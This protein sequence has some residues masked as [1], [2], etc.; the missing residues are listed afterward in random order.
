MFQNSCKRWCLPQV[1][2][3]YFFQ[4][5]KKCAGG[6]H[7]LWIWPHWRLSKSRRSL[8]PPVI[9]R[10]SVVSAFRFRSLA[11][12]T[13]DGK[14][15]QNRSVC[16]WGRVRRGHTTSVSAFNSFRRRRLTAPISTRGR[17]PPNPR[18]HKRCSR[19][20]ATV[21]VQHTYDNNRDRFARGR[22]PRLKLL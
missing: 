9:G 18:S 12:T 13:D 6:V 22:W 19:R 8:Q 20:S 2:L 11:R 15:A 10:A 7:E 21:F 5:Q 3:T 14:T 17:N 1:E 4:A 16:I